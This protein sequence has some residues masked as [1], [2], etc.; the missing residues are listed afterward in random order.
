ML[1][2]FLSEPDYSRLGYSLRTLHY[3]PISNCSKSFNCKSAALSFR[4]KRRST[5]VRTSLVVMLIMRIMQLTLSTAHASTLECQHSEHALLAIQPYTCWEPRV[6]V[7]C[8]WLHNTSVRC[9]RAC[10]LPTTAHNSL[11]IEH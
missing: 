3:H 11:Q 7:Y 10:T 8:S 4:F 6:E 2:L 1:S 9:L 5:I